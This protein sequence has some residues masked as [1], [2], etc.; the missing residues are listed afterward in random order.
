V[1]LIHQK[2]SIVGARQLAQVGEGSQVTVH[3]E[4]GLGDKE[5]APVLGGKMAEVTLGLVETEVG[6]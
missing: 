6:I 1:G 2:G 3:A 4:Q 5:A